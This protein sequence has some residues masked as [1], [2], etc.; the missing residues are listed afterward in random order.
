MVAVGEQFILVQPPQVPKFGVSRHAEV[1]L[2]DHHRAAENE[3][4]EQVQVQQVPGAPEA[5]ANICENNF[6]PQKL[7]KIIFL[8]NHTFC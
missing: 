3:R 2:E 8:D 5:S 6:M 7:F 1:V 4:A